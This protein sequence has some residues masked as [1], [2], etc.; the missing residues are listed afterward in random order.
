MLPT[1]KRK[2]KKKNTKCWKILSKKYER[3]KKKKQDL[4]HKKSNTQERRL[5]LKIRL[6]YI[7]KNK[8]SVYGCFICLMFISIKFRTFNGFKFLW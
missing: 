6:K 3:E 2:N 4:W 5:V 1:Y 7:I 8:R